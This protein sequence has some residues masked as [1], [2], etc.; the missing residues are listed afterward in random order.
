MKISVKNGKPCEKI[1]KI[2]IDPAV[3]RKEYDSFYQAIAP[4]AKVPGFRPGKAPP[5][6]LAMHYRDEARKEV[7][8]HLISNSFRQ[9]LKEESLDPLGYPEI[10]EVQFSDERLSYQATVE[11][12]P[13]IKLAKTTGLKAEKPDETVKPEEIEAS[14]RRVQKSQAQYKTVEGRNAQR[15]DYVVVDYTCLVNGQEIDKRTEDWIPIQEEEY[16]KGFSTQLLGAL[17]GESRE[18]KINLP[19]N[20]FR[21]EFS[22]KEAVFQVQIKEIKEEILPPLDDELAKSA[23]EYQT[24]EELKEKIRIELA[25]TKERNAESAYEKALLDELLKHNKFD[26]PEGVVARRLENL[27]HESL[28]N[29]ERHGF[30]KDKL[31]EISKDLSKD[32]EPEARRQVQMAFLLDEIATAENFTASPEDLKAKYQKIADQ[33]RQPLETVEHY[34]GENEEARTSLSEQIRNEKAIDYLK[35]NAK[36]K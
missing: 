25:K 8:S 13:R 18:I 16:L 7:L 14:L 10:K 26:L 5:S 29:Y 30:P 31:A 36:A 21:K 22:G 19:E 15:T 23:G 3:I 4:K 6:V 9:A 2:E 28:A 34:Y 12:R 35:K 33:V 20:F 24:L 17:A 32:L 11:I 1:L 27:M